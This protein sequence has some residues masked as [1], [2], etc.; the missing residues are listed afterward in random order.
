MPDMWE[1]TDETGQPL[2][3]QALV[4]AMKA[5]SIS[6][7]P[8][9]RALLFQ[10]L[11]ESTLIVATPDRPDEPRMRT[12]GPGEHMNLVTL[13]DADGT[14]LPVFTSTAAVLAWRPDG[15]GIVALPARALLEMALAAGTGKIAVNPG[16]PTFG[17]VTRY[18]IEALA[19]GRMPL[20]S[21]G[22]VV[23]QPTEVRIGIPQTPP[24][25]ATLNALRKALT[26]QPVAERA[27]YY[28]MQQGQSQPELCV[29]LQLVSGVAQD[30][31]RSAMRSVVERAG[32][33][34]Q[35]ARS[36]LFMVADDHL[37]AS[38]E[39]GAG[40]LFFQRE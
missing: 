40:Q 10:L 28:L 7:T 31:E 1:P 3:N 20:G 5:V 16:S 24:D 18:E 8:E 23:A 34:S 38:L 33:E 2:R 39:A 12:A 36:L 19:R 22:D 32:A 30:A 37:R 27:W 17:Y 25:P 9:R 14:V 6:D 4:E 15:T 35:E 11:L 21:A 13:R 26:A 29:A